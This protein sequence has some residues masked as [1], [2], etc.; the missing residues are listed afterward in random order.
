MVERVTVA[1]VARRQAILDGEAKWKAEVEEMGMEQGGRLPLKQKEGAEG[2]L[3]MCDH[4]AMWGTEY[5]VS[6][7]CFYYFFC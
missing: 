2:E 5:Q 7:W 6:D 3:I 4:C 1:A